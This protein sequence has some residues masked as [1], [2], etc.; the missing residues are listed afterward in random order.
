MREGA[1][2]SAKDGKFAWVD[3]HAR[4]IQRK[5]DAMAIG[6]PEKV[7]D[8]IRE[9]KWDFNGEGREQILATVME[10]GFIRMRGHGSFWTFEFTMA[11]EK[12]LWACFDFLLNFAGPFTQCRFNN[13]RTGETIDMTFQDFKAAMTEDT[14]KVLRVATVMTEEQFPKKASFNSHLLRRQAAGYPRLMQIMKGLV[15][16]ITTFGIMSV[17]NPQNTP[18]SEPE[19]KKR[20]ESFKRVLGHAQY[21][22][23][24]HSGNYNGFE[25]SF[26]VMNVRLSDMTNWCDADHYDQESYIFGE[27]NSA[28]REVTFTLYYGTTPG[29]QR[30]VVLGLGEDVDNY[31]SEYK[32]RKFIIPFFDDDY[33]PTDEGMSNL[34]LGVPFAKEDVEDSEENEPHLAMI[35]AGNE[36]LAADALGKTAGMCNYHKRGLL[37]QAVRKLNIT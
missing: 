8:K 13:L 32:G 11:S 2:I 12:A 21:G 22:Y 25:K 28:K 20:R 36:A 7:F 18:L 6:V 16:K 31:Y 19:N 10:A 23:V 17:D 3:E 26:F 9:M 5:E 1:W 14:S 34:P 24:Q 27:V 33:A 35:Y 37:L 15:P 30:K 4:F 29:A